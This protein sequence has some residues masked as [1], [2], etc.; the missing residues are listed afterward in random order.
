MSSGFFGCLSRPGTVRRLAEEAAA[1]AQ[2]RRAVVAIAS[3]AV[4]D[5]LDR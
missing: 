5:N 1:D 4:G 2:D 3:T